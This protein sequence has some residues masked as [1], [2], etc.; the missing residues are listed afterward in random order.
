M[1]EGHLRAIL[2]EWVTHYNRGRPHASLGPGLPDPPKDQVVGA[3]GYK[4]PDAHRV[5]A[6]PILGGFR[7]EFRLER[8]AA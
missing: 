2:R 6:T 5:V 4:L 3:N 1:N 8:K 7:H